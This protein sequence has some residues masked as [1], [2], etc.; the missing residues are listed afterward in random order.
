[1]HS[2][3]RAFTNPP[4]PP[5]KV[6]AGCQA[7]QFGAPEGR[8]YSVAEEASVAVPAREPPSS[9]THNDPL[10]APQ[11]VA[12]WCHANRRRRGRL[13]AEVGWVRLYGFDA[14]PDRYCACPPVC[15]SHWGDGRGPRRSSNRVV[16]AEERRGRVV[17]GS[18]PFLSDPRRVGHR[19]D[20]TR[21]RSRRRHVGAGQPGCVDDAHGAGGR[22][23]SLALARDS[24]RAGCGLAR[25]IGRCR[26]G[27]GSFVRRC[28][29][30]HRFRGCR[31]TT[32]DHH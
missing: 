7:S 4:G 23:V 1:M 21:A 10:G 19:E 9:A 11:Y 2:T 31:A 3:I 18:R 25:G 20:G 27:R 26:P 32:D 8:P 29:R 13:V 12:P 17:R 22:A 16:R 14:G 30:G 24:P 28:R 5:D 6:A 15:G